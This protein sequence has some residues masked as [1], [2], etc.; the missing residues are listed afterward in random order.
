MCTLSSE[1]RWRARAGWGLCSQLLGAW[2]L[3]PKGWKKEPF[4]QQR[5]CRE[6]V[7]LLGALALSKKKKKASPWTTL[8]SYFFFYK[9]ST[10]YFR[11]ILTLHVSYPVVSHS[12]LPP[13]S[14][15]LMND[16]VSRWS[17]LG[18]PLQ[19]RWKSG[20]GPTQTLFLGHC[21]SVFYHTSV[22][23]PAVPFWY[24][25]SAFSAQQNAVASYKE[26][27]NGLIGVDYSTK[28]APW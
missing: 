27:R 2:S 24:F 20:S 8:P 12:L 10:C 17:S 9:V 14:F 13:F 6:Q 26:T 15:R 23:S 5:N 22:T 3:S 19:R 18:L 1:R 7:N 16:R 28:F 21:E 11:T 4:P 25:L